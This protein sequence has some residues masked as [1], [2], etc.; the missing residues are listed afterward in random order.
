[1]FN[2]D[3]YLQIT[4][5]HDLRFYTISSYVHDSAN[6]PSN[7]GKNLPISKYVCTKLSKI[8]NPRIF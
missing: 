4:D 5:V 2:S 8:L 6:K 3:L 1:M 7:S